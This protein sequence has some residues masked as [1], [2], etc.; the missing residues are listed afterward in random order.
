MTDSVHERDILDLL[1]A[2]TEIVDSE[3]DLGHRARLLGVLRSTLDEQLE[4]RLFRLVYD[5]SESGWSQQDIADAV[6]M[7]RLTVGIWLRRYK[8]NHGI[9]RRDQRLEQDLADAIVLR[10]GY[11][12]GS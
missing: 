8:D 7:S 11:K 6:S 9:P 5:L 4:V 3:P 2:I 10:S 1:S 12:P